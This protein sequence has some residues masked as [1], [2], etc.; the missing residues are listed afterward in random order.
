MVDHEGGDGGAAAAAAAEADKGE[1]E[2]H[3]PSHPREVDILEKGE[4][5][6][7]YRPKVETEHPTSVD[8]IQRMYMVLKPEH[9]KSKEE[10]KQ[11]H[12]SGKESAKHTVSDNDSKDKPASEHAAGRRSAEGDNKSHEDNKQADTPE[13]KGKKGGEGEEKVNVEKQDLLRF[14]IL[15]RKSLPD[16]SKRTRPYWGFVDLVTTDIK[17]IAQALGPEEYETKTRGKRHKPAGRAVGEGVYC[18]LKHKKG[19]QLHIHLIYKLELP[20]SEKAHSPQIEMNIEEE[21]SF[22]IQVKNPNQSTPPNAGLGNK[23]K[24]TYPAHLQGNMGR[25]RFVSADPCDFLN[26]E[27]CEFILISASDN[28]EEELGVHLDVEHDEKC[29]ALL[30]LLGKKEPLNV[31]PL[32]EGE[33]A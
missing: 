17:D 10:I 5:F 30:S 20:K 22:L 33:W 28:I 1:E 4:V 31:K 3:F 23:R 21:G 24:A 15:G 2:S 8:D 32:L 27:G 26:Y 9:S 11:S 13:E 18:I 16:A 19:N 7:F 6:F 29:S 14:I 25:Y 12:D